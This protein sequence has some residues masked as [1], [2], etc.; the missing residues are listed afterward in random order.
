MEWCELIKAATCDQ[1]IF[2][3][4]TPANAQQNIIRPLKV[5]ATCAG[6]LK[7]WQLNSD[8]VKEAVLLVRE[9]Q[10]SGKLADLVVGVV[11]NI[12][13]TNHLAEA[14]PLYPTL[15]IHRLPIQQNRKSRAIKTSEQLLTDLEQRKISERLPERKAFWELMR[16][17]FTER[18]KTLVDALR[19]AAI[20]V[21]VVG[22]LRI[23]KAV[24]LPADWK[25][26]REYFDPSGRP[27]GEL[28]GCSRALMLRY[29]AEKQQD[30]RSD[31]VVL[32][33]SAQ[34]VPAIFEELLTEALDESVRLAQPLRQTLKLQMET[35][36]LLP[37][38]QPNELITAFEAYTR[39][40]GNPFWLDLPDTQADEYV[41]RY[42]QD[43]NPDIFNELSCHQ[44]EQYQ[45]PGGQRK[46]DFAMYVYFNRLMK[47]PS[48]GAR[49]IIFRK[50]TG[51]IYAGKRMA[52]NEVYFRVDELEAFITDAAPTKLSDRQPLRL[53][54][55]DLQPWEFLFLTPKRSLAE[56]RNGGLCDVTRYFAIGIPDTTFLMLALGEFKDRTSLF[57]RYGLTD[58]DRSLIL[59]SHSLRHLQ[60]T[61]LFRMGLAD[62]II[63]KRF[64]R[65][66]VAQSYEYDHRSLA[67]ELEQI[68][69]PPEIEVALGD[70]AS[71]VAR[72][73]QSGKATGPLV[74]C[75]K[76]IQS[77][78][79]DQAAFEFLKVEADGF[80]AT[81]YGYCINS[82]TVD[83]CPKNLE[84]FAG[85][86][87]LTATNLPEN[88]HLETLRYK[89][90]AALAETQARPVSTVGRENQIA[91]AT[92]RL[93]SI[94]RLLQTPTGQLVFPDGQD[95]SKQNI[96]KSVLDG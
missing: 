34:Y 15:R 89:F 68:E 8:V 74:D 9:S 69:I 63:T 36:R 37:W 93:E 70:N 57:Q 14:S 25:R 17:V 1:L 30:S 88:H 54:E 92:I 40:T 82:F 61:E 33:E 32:F 73:I 95:L 53:A 13:D 18:P 94:K 3:R 27:A 23:G 20:K 90:E 43:F 91:H 10:P 86:S 6:T 12:I 11:K 7:P 48:R 16:I 96:A 4:N 38:Y 44:A 80:H 59:T 75:F 39:L 58:A 19:F 46:L 76:R 64:N 60:N 79:G 21:M 52:W 31:S 81:P 72:L 66:N 47:G 71:T 84:C 51:D 67:E 28:G 24:R 42:Q 87:H 22:E 78:Q 83:P 85:C 26:T 29:F 45:R 35:Q 55:G 77:E 56:E 49:P 5:L 65:R 41:C 50:S 62:T 2:R